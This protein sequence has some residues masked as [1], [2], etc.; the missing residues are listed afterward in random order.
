MAASGSIHTIA[1]TGEGI[2]FPKIIKITQTIS[3]FFFGKIEKFEKIASSWAPFLGFLKLLNDS[4][5]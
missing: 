2:R 4:R 1:Y 5:Y 3:K